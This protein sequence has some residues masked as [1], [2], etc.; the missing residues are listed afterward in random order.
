M[1]YS[2]ILS[3]IKRGKLGVD[4]LFILFAIVGSVA[5][6]AYF[7]QRFKKNKEIIIKNR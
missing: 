3:Q 2:P 1:R 6:P 4:N 5:L 7:Y